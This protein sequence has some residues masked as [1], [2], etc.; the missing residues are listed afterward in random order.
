MT[1]LLLQ[2]HHSNTR[3]I[4]LNKQYNNPSD[5]TRY[6]FLQKAQ[7]ICMNNTHHTPCYNPRCIYFL[8]ILIKNNRRFKYQCNVIKIGCQ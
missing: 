1:K 3:C 4:P 7:Q 5:F 2:L 8:Q 6:V